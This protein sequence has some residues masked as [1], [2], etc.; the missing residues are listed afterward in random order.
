MKSTFS[1]AVHALA[2]LAHTQK[3]ETSETLAK[4]ACT[5]PAKIR[6]T[7]STLKQ[8]G[9]IQTIEGKKGGY[10]INKDPQTITLKEIA[11]ALSFVFINPTW[12]SGDLNMDCLISSGMSKVMDEVYYN[13]NQ[14]CL[15]QLE[16]ITLHQILTLLFKKERRTYETL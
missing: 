12:Q 14:A 4:N 6:K 5:H 3:I 15:Q 9:M 13:M 10:Q 2:Y 7:M 1:L 16:H 11:E 8:S